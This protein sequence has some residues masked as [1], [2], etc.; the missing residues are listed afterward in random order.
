MRQIQ[1]K[2]VSMTAWPRDSEREKE[3]FYGSGIVSER[4]PKIATPP[5]V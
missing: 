5:S 3:I 4:P 1:I 2:S